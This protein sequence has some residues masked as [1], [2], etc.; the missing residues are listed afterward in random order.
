[1]TRKN[2]KWTPLLE[3]GLEQI[4]A[5][6]YDATS[7]WTFYRIADK[8]GLSK[9]IYKLFLKACG[10]RRKGFKEGWTPFTLTDDSRQIKTK[11]NGA[12]SYWLFSQWFG[13]APEVSVWQF[14]PIYVEAWVEANA[15]M[16]QFDHLLPGIT[17]RPLKGDWSIDGKWKATEEIAM[18]LCDG[19]DVYILY[20]GDCDKKG[21]EIPESAWNQIQRWLKDG[22]AKQHLLAEKVVGQSKIKFIY[23]GLTEKQ[24]RKFKLIESV[25]DKAKPGEYQWESLSDEQAREVIKCTLAKIPLDKLEEAR[26]KARVTRTDWTTKYFNELK[27]KT[28]G[29]GPL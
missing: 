12:S 28:E 20:F 21:R 26:E 13:E 4:K 29:S 18:R 15:M 2:I 27:T 9:K 22:T 8:F 14:C 10:A 3:W 7:R 25:G 1:M 24:A 23:G 16:S 5:L 17:L 11:G 19:K 6:A